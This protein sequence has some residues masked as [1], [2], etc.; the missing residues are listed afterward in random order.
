MNND[1]KRIL[2]SIILAPIFLLTI[3]EGGYY[4]LTLLVAIFLFG[5][6]EILKIN[7][8]YIQVILFLFLIA[9]LLC[10]FLIR[11]LENGIFYVFF[12]VIITWLSDTG[13]FIF[14]KFLNGKK[15]K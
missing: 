11:E 2:S 6:R 15:L 13:G 7:L 1:L 8:K 10:L 3:Y 14:G 9:F 4:F 5:L 12:I